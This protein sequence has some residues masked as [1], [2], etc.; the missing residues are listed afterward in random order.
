M[1]IQVTNDDVQSVLQSSPMVALQVENAALKRHLKASEIALEAAMDEL[2][3]LKGIDEA[4][5]KG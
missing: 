1:E 4:T 5:Q 2:K 3:I